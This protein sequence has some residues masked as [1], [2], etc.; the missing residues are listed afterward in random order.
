MPTLLQIWRDVLPTATWAWAED[1][2]PPASESVQGARPDPEIGWVRVLRARVPALEGLEAADLAI[3]PE[4]ALA[5]L[6]AGGADPSV[7][8]TEMARA[9][10]AAL[11]LVGRL[12]PGTSAAELAESACA[13]G[14]P[15]LHLESGDPGA[16]ERSVVGYLV[17]RRAELDR[18]AG[19]VADQVERLA[20]QGLGMDALAGAV[21]AA[22]G[23]AVAIEDE[24]GAAVAIHAPDGVAEAGAAAARYLAQTRVAAL[25]VPLPG[26]PSAG[27]LALLGPQPAS[28]LDRAVAE[29]VAP[30]VALEL[31]RQATRPASGGGVLAAL[32]ADGPPWAVIVARQLVR[33]EDLPLEERER[34]RDRLVRLAPPRRLL[35]RGDVTSLEYRLVVALGPDDPRG[36][37]VAGRIAAAVGRDVA[38]SRPF[39]EPGERSAAEAEARATLEAVEALPRAEAPAGGQPPAAGLPAAAEAPSPHEPRGAP[40]PPPSHAA[41]GASA[42]GRVML[43]ERLPVYRMLGELHN[44]PNGARLAQALLAPLLTGSPE[45]RR[46]RIATLRAVLDHPA[47]ATAAQALGVHRNT[48]QYRVAR[49]EALT[50][51]QLDDPDLRLALAVAVR[52][53][54][55]DQSREPPAP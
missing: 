52:V 17:N 49:I 32:P 43:A 42:R 3:V 54:Q 21:G 1:A 46:R 11:L 41:R 8:G 29:R 25:R 36:L 45:T 40:G 18:R 15:A 30:L 10:V 2:P 47:S 28:A 4:P 31:G 44:L 51:W 9:G 12:A 55:N 26:V 33:G 38:L 23:R 19:E 37:L 16:L 35:L 14:L 48:L 20:L 24:Q 50:G 13:H 53:V 27:S 7:L 39:R 6:V 22:L 34:R 5:A